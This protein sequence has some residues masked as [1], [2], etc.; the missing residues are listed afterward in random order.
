MTDIYER[1]ESG[2]TRV[3][4]IRD[5][6]GMHPWEWNDYACNL[7]CW[8]EQTG[9]FLPYK[10]RDTYQFIDSKEKM[11]EWLETK[12]NSGEPYAAWGIRYLDH[13]GTD[14]VADKDAVAGF[15]EDKDRIECW[16]GMIFIDHERFKMYI[17]DKPQPPEDEL[18][19]MEKAISMEFD[20]LLAYISSC[21]F[22]FTVETKCE[23]CNSWVLKDSFCGF[24]CITPDPKEMYAAMVDLFDPENPDLKTIAKRMTMS[25]V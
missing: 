13:Y 15:N 16:D 10:E 24:E 23:V 6:E 19:Y 8:N 9:S 20:S 14:F 18:K 17:N 2:N 11:A 4:I 22:G 1:F 7:A 21:Q 12:K 25:L 5:E 3:T